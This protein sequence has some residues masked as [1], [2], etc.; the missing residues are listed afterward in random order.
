MEDYV[1]PAKDIDSD[2]YWISAKRPKAVA[3]LQR[4]FLQA[5]WD[6]LIT[7]IDSQIDDGDKQHPARW[8]AKLSSYYLGEE[9][10]I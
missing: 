9:P 4:A 3:A 10:V 8:L 2:D 6:V 5:K 7:T 1:N